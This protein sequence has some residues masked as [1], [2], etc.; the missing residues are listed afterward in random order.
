VSPE[1]THKYPNAESAGKEWQPD[2]AN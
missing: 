2:P 1:A